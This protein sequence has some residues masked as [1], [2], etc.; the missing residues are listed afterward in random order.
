[1]R[2]T[3]TN[4]GA[5]IASWSVTFSWPRAVSP[6]SGVG[7]Y[8][9]GKQTVAN[10]AWNGK[11]ARNGSTTFGFTDTSATQPRPTSCTAKAN[12]VNVTC[13]VR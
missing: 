7:T 11:L 8:A 3:V 2:G 6:W 13:A 12:G 9:N 5:A 10:E 1:M 4:T